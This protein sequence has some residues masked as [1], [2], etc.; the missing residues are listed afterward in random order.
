[1][2]M[3][4]LGASLLTRLRRGAA[5]DKN[6][7]RRS[8]DR[9]NVTG[10]APMRGKGGRAAPA[11][12][13]S[14]M[15]ARAEKNDTPRRHDKRPTGKGARKWSIPMP[16]GQVRIED[17]YNRAVDAAADELARSVTRGLAKPPFALLVCTV[18]WLASLPLQAFTNLCGH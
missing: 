15:M 8:G 18:T 13:I 3:I 11:H 2:S 6:L 14:R 10:M 9:A 12:P 4:I 17:G 16:D 1:M 7:S 5:A